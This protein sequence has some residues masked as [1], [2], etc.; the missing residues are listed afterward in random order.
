[1]RTAR[2]QPLGRRAGPDARD[3]PVRDRRAVCHGCSRDQCRPL[4]AGQ[5]TRPGHC[6]R[7]CAGRSAGGSQA[8]GRGISAASAS[9]DQNWTG[10]SVVN[11]SELGR[12]PGNPHGT[13][14]AEDL[15]LTV[16]KDV[17]ALF[18]GLLTPF[19]V[20]VL[21]VTAKARAFAASEPVL[22]INQVSPIALYCDPDPGGCRTSSH[23]RL[24]V[25]RGRQRIVGDL[26]LRR[27]P[28]GPRTGRAGSSFSPIELPAP[29]RETSRPTSPA[30]HDRR[31]EQLQPDRCRGVQPR[32]RPAAPG[33]PR[34]RAGTAPAAVRREDHQNNARSC[35]TTRKRPRM[36]HISSR[37]TTDFP[38]IRQAAVE[39][40]DV[41]RDRV[42]IVRVHGGRQ[43]H[44]TALA[45]RL[46][47]TIPQAVRRRLASERQR[48][49]WGIERL[50]R[51]GRGPDRRS[52]ALGE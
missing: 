22:T 16:Q 18:G 32:A 38:G 52:S 6:R 23:A 41:P 37:S 4:V 2:R 35:A 9:A 29:R 51:A 28:S 31:I 12:Y 14:T 36:R 40:A 13:R 24:P 19:G 50:R 43:R 34:R 39:R 7:R 33:A 10:S 8:L 45:S 11:P 48:L 21:S 44:D 30:T 47:G 27:R 42:G 46:Q 49:R 25:A 15:R 3:V 26:R 5:A 20:P 1:M 17:P